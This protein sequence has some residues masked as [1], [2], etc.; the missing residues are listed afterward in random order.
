M[1]NGNILEPSPQL[2]QSNFDPAVAVPDQSGA[3]DASNANN[4]ANNSVFMGANTPGKS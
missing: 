3:N 2:F 4:N 1:Q